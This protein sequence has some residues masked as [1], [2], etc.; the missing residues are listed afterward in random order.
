MPLML[1]P[2]GY[3]RI[4]N[5]QGELAV[6][7]AAA[8]AGVPYSLSTMATRSIEEVAAI[9]PDADRWFQV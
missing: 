3:T 1:S 6:M 5:S 8:R 2:T 7:R 4:T 9:A